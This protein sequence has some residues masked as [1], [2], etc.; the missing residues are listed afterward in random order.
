MITVAYLDVTDRQT[1]R[2]M[3]CSAYKWHHAIRSILVTLTVMTPVLKKQL[4]AFIIMLRVG[5]WQPDIK[6]HDK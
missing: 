1:G 5:F 6:I 2:R 4:N 3:Q